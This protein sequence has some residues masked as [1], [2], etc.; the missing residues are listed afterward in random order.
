ME[1]YDEYRKKTVQAKIDPA[2]NARQIHLA[3]Q[4]AV[5]AEF[6]MNDTHWDTYLQYIQHARDHIETQLTSCKEQLL[7]LQT[8]DY[9]IIIGLKLTIA[10]L[11][12]Q[13]LALDWAVSLPT[14]IKTNGDLARK[15]QKET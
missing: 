14:D 8:I 13:L 10:S 7:K 1:T 5:S 2:I 12:G 15:L 4:A 9:N 3:T 11:T 6:L